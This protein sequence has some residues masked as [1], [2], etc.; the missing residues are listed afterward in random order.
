MKFKILFFSLLSLLWTQDIPYFDG[1]IAMQHL[2]KQCEFG[3]RYPGSEAHEKMAKYF[4]QFL[5]PLSDD[6][7]VMHEQVLHPMSSD[8]VNL[9]NLLARYN[10]DHPFRLLFLAHWDTR[11][12]ADKDPAEENRKTPILGA[13][14]GASGIAVLMALAQILNYAP[15]EIGID[16]LFVD[17]EDMGV[18]SQSDSW[19]LGTREFSKRMPLPYPEYAV[20]L[21]MIGDAELDLPIE[22]FSYMQAPDVV[23]K[24]WGIASMLGYTQFKMEM[25]SPILDDH[26]VL[27]QNTKIPSVD[28]IDFH[29]P[30]KD[31]NYWHTL[32]DTPDK[33]SPASLE[34]V[35]TVITTLIYTENE[36]NR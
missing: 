36:V 27:W 6:L 1:S 16:L 23:G 5:K 17:G 34:A 8:T 13:N 20:C 32:E 26:R 24:I 9:T 30:N 11:E 25:G 29:Y 7:M 19:G 3:P 4:E 12:I 33:C 28:I 35:G 21:D 31:M 2:E 15:T 10:P 14:D 22:Q 18:N